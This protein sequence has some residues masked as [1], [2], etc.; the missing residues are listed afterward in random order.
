MFEGGLAKCLKVCGN[1]CDWKWA[2]LTK[3]GREK[4]GEG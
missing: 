2:F 4:H 3:E 1:S